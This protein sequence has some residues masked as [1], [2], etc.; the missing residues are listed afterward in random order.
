ME[1]PPV[2]LACPK[3]RSLWPAGFESAAKAQSCPGCG[4]ETL[5]R[6]FPAL[7][8]TPAQGRVGE[9]AVAEGEATCFFHPQKRAAVP[10]DACGRFLCALCD[11]EIGD[12]HL[13]PGCLE[14]GARKQRVHSLE[15]ARTRWDYL[16]WTALIVPSLLTCGFALPIVSVVVLVLAIWKR[17]A[18]PGLV[19]NS[20]LNLKLAIFA[21]AVGLVGG[22]IFWVA[23]AMSG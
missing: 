3:C 20:A 10:C 23:V 4:T 11:C 12:Q 17:K 7:H 2:Q 18:P 19:G 6:S 13:C 9:P 15:Q 16:A 1:V 14:G 22:I 21:A 8:R 5:A